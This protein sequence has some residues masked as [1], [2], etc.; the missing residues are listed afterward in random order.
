MIFTKTTHLWVVKCTFSW[1]TQVFFSS[2]RQAINSPLFINDNIPIWSY[3]NLRHWHS[4]IF[5]AHFGRWWLLYCVLFLLHFVF[6]FY[7]Y[8]RLFFRPLEIYKWAIAHQNQ[9]NGMWAQRT[10]I[11][12]GIRPVWSESLL[13]KRKLRSLA[14]H[15][16]HSED[17][18]QTGWMPRLIRV[19][20]GHT[21]H[22]VGFVVLRL[23][24]DS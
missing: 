7:F 14:T 17:S 3:G 9:Q 18:E 2:S 4:F 21:G 20:A 11:S 19:F 13:F 24:R 5:P 1:N 8:S 16:T 12:Q 22:F 6:L 10:Q 23:K 15:Y